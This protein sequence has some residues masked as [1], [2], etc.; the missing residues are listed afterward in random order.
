MPSSVQPLI[1]ASD[2]QRGGERHVQLRLRDGRVAWLILPDGDLDE[3]LLDV[4]EAAI[5]RRLGAP[6]DSAAV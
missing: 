5:R 2:R 4:Y 3:Q 1:L 6:P